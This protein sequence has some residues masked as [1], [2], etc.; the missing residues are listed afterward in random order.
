MHHMVGV[1]GTPCVIPP[2]NSDSNSTKVH[3]KFCA[4]EYYYSESNAKTERNLFAGKPYSDQLDLE[5][6][7]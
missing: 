5:W 6:L 2:N 3:V 1:H 4:V 7:H